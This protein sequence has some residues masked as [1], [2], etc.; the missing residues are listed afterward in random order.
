M[1]KPHNQQV[2]INSI[3][4]NPINTRRWYVN[5]VEV[6]NPYGDE[7]SGSIMAVADDELGALLWFKKW[8][9][10]SNRG[11]EVVP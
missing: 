9:A 8:V 4:P 3:T 2:T 1:K 5:W 10:D 11:W 7:S 6:N